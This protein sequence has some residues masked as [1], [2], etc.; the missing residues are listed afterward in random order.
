MTEDTNSQHNLQGPCL[1]R[2]CL[3]LWLQAEVA[4]LLRLP[5]ALALSEVLQ[6]L[7]AEVAEAAM[8]LSEVLIQLSLPLQ[9]NSG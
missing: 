5:A 1:A 4:V 8:A 6:Q 9:R 3:P 2:S 7:P